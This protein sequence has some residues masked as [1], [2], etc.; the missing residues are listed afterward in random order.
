VSDVYLDYNATAPVRPQACEAA[1][2]ALSAVGNPSSVH[3]AG[4]A[5]RAVIEDA[6]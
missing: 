1:I 4:R 2:A 6:R 5:A 3:G